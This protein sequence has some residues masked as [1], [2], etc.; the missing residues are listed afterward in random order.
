MRLECGLTRHAAAAR[1]GVARSTWDRIERG[2]PVVSVANLVAASDAVGLDLVCS[3]YPG[4]PPGLRD[5]GQLAIAQFLEE[6]AHPTWSVSLEEP[7]GD[8]GEAI[9]MV[10]GG[11]TEIIAVEIERLLVDWQAQSRRWLAKRAWLAQRHARPVRLVVVVADSPRNRDVVRPFTALIDRTMP[12]GT[13]SVM[14][15]ISTGAPLA[16]DGRCWIRERRHT[17]LAR[18]R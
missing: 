1:A 14:Q 9:D 13:R 17:G 11:P 5:S 16:H 8:H 4:R 3:L 18:G 6:R 10:F 7:A 12:A 2:S 15:S